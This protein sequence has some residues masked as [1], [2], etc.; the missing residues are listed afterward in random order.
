MGKR[1]PKLFLI[2]PCGL[3]RR[4]MEF[5]E[6]PFAL[7]GSII[8]VRVRQKWYSKGTDDILYTKLP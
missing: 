2:Y 1:T 3:E 7:G 4:I 6:L 5:R 8:E